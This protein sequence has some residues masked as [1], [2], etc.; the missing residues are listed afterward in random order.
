[1][2]LFLIKWDFRFIG[3]LLFNKKIIWSVNQT[4]FSA[5][6]RQITKNDYDEQ[7]KHQFLK[8]IFNI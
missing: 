1:M 6:L 4:T 7:K 8:E 3:L 5:K 2:L